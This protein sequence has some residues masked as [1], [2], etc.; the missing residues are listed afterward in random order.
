[1]SELKNMKEKN[2]ALLYIA[3][4]YSVNFYTLRSLWM[5][6]ITTGI[7]NTRKINKI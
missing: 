4:K 7:I 3:K 2:D 6:Y 1:M 5:K